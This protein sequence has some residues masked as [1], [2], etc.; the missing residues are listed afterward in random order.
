M[1]DATDSLAISRE[2]K[3]GTEP[4][5]SRHFWYFIDTL[6][7]ET[8]NTCFHTNKTLAVEVSFAFH[9]KIQV[10]DFSK[11]IV[12][13]FLILTQTNQITFT[14]IHSELNFTSS[15]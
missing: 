13:F 7:Q 6:T 3:N 4:C 9:C 15:S 8:Q 10:V 2:Y 12:K 1:C 14:A 11:I 5:T